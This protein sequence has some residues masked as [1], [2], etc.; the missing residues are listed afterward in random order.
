LVQSIHIGA[1]V[2]GVEGVK[3]VCMELRGDGGGGG[4]SSDGG[5]VEGRWGR[6]G[7]HQTIHFEM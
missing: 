3:I 6:G 7:R 5:G 2:E 1:W 4:G